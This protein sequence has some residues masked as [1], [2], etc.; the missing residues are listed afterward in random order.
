MSYFISPGPDSSLGDV[1]YFHMRRLG[2]P[3]LSASC[4][5]L[6]SRPCHAQG[7]TCRCQVEL[8]GSSGLAEWDLVFSWVWGTVIPCRRSPFVQKF[9]NHFFFHHTHNNSLSVNE[10]QMITLNLG[11]LEVEDLIYK[12]WKRKRRERE[13]KSAPE[14]TSLV[15]S[16]PWNLAAFIFCSQ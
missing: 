4:N 6:P 13:A 1:Y 3:D 11:T 5:Q 16:S 12:S 15:F 7:D 14:I 10:S 2:G 9:L 8:Q